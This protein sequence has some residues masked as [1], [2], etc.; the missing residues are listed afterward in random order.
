METDEIQLLNSISPFAGQ[1]DFAPRK[2]ATDLVIGQSY[3]AKTIK[4]VC[5]KFGDVYVVHSDDFQLFLPK[6]FSTINIAERDENR[7]FMLTGFERMRNGN[8]S[9]TY[10][11]ARL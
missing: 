7:F 6:R 1:K 5:G 10:Q 8:S 3:P 2:T 9:P 11:F 4:K